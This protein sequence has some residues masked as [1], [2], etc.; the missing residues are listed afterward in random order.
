MGLMQAYYAAL[1]RQEIDHYQ[2]VLDFATSEGITLPSAQ[3]QQQDR[4]LLADLK[5][6]GVWDKL[7]CFARFTGTAPTAFK[8]L[9]WKRLARMSGMG[10]LL[11]T[12]NG[13]EGN[14]TDAYVNTAFVPSLH[15]QRMALGGAAIGWVG[16]KN[17]SGTMAL[18][19]AQG[20]NKYD[21]AIIPN[22]TSNINYYQ[23]FCAEST[24]N[25]VSM[26]RLGTIG[27]N[28]LCRITTSAVAYISPS[29]TTSVSHG[30]AGLPDVPVHLLASSPRGG[31]P[32]LF[33]TENLKYFYAGGNL[34]NEYAAMTAALG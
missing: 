14:G 30:A 19:H 25:G 13:V 34:Q 15:A 10:G 3:Q 26:S 32:G 33:S 24:Q 8:L 27:H 2:L 7:D 31:A 23:L 16:T 11:W 5:S 28:M 12:E 22:R 17:P 18:V 1:L 4:Q 6:A 29:G 9:D 20:V 21:I